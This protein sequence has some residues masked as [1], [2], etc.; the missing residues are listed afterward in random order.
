MYAYSVYSGSNQYP[1]LF[2]CA[3]RNSLLNNCALTKDAELGGGDPTG[4]GSDGGGGGGGGGDIAVPPA[5]SPIRYTVQ[6]GD[7][8]TSIAEANVLTQQVDWI[9]ICNR[10]MLP[11]CNVIE[12][13]QEL[14]IP[15]DVN[16]ASAQSAADGGGSGGVIAGVVITLLVLAGA[17]IAFAIWKKKQPRAAPPPPKQVVVE[18]G[19]TTA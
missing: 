1:C 6:A 12:V 3:D 4:G 19:A 13:G 7:T 15:C 18:V 14:T 17:L 11:D 8:L 9:Q 5:C 2:R 10:N 16:L